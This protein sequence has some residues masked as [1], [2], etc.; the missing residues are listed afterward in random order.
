MLEAS[1][2]LFATASRVTAAA[3][4]LM[5]VGCSSVRDDEAEMTFFVAHA[6]PGKGGD[7]G[8]L[9]GADEHCRKLAAAAGSQRRDW[10]AYLST[11][12]Q[13]GRP[14]VNA[15]DRIGRG[16]WRNAKGVVIA[17]DLEQLHGENL[18]TKQTALDEVG[19]IVNG[20]GD[21]PNK[22]DMITGSTLDG[23][24]FPPGEDRTCG[25]YRSSG[26][27]AVQLGH[28]DRSGPATNPTGTSWN[29]AHLSE[30][31]PDGGCSQNDMNSQGG[32]GLF[33]CF[34]GG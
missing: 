24:A 9:E 1:S 12:A 17:R 33:Y 23:R 26:M 5:A 3:L 7:L 32:Q 18:L 10:H 19:N 4:V 15:R 14:A 2:W 20:R 29:S 21:K 6:G 13:P 31:G 27:G 16:P 30:G 22:H 28:H 34:A 8:G 25:N 11:Q